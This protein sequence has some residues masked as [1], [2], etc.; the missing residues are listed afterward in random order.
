MANWQIGT[1]M[2]GT[3]V[4]DRYYG[5]HTPEHG[6]FTPEA[7][8]LTVQRLQAAGVKWVR[9]AM[10]W[11]YMQP[12]SSFANTL[13]PG[14]VGNYTD[15][16]DKLRAAGIEIMAVCEKPASWCY[17]ANSLEGD[18]VKFASVMGRIAAQFKDKITA[19]QIFN[20]VDVNWTSAT[21]YYNVLSQCYGPI[22]A[23][24][25]NALVV[26]SGLTYNLQGGTTSY[27]QGLYDLGC[28]PY[29][30]IFAPHLYPQNGHQSLFGPYLDSLRSVMTNNGDTSDMW[31]TEFGL[32][33]AT[34]FATQAD[35]V[36]FANTYVPIMRSKSYIK[37]I[38]WY[39]MI[40][41]TAPST[42]KEANFGVYMY[43]GTPK[44]VH[45]TLQTL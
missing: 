16:I 41:H 17:G 39:E 23:A 14:A 45:E 7:R 5:L 44:P 21:N 18:P 36:T 28:G 4:V 12:D 27:L 32:P 29:F 37:R 33:S 40:D 25:P 9:I 22:K 10:L 19:Y 38:N 20:E 26:L 35:Q 30:D 15:Y 43:D 6:G 2:A 31:V 8:T 1:G 24:D 34:G 3:G 42:D 11:M 13:N